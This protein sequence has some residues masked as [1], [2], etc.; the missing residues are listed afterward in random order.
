M[1]LSR[2]LGILD[3][4]ERWY[5]ME[6]LSGSLRYIFKSAKNLTFLMPRIDWMWLL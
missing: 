3:L 2:F 4:L 5:W 6:K 1:L